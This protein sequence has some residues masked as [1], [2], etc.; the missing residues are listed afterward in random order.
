MSQRDQIAS[1][2]VIRGFSRYFADR[3]ERFSAPRIAERME[4][5]LDIIEK[6][7]QIYV[8]EDTG[9]TKRSFYRRVVTRGESVEAQFG[10]SENGEIYYLQY[11]YNPRQQVVFRKATAIPKWLDVAVEEK[12]LEIMAIIRG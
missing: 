10:Y 8:P 2:Q 5:A 4:Q 3:L 9:A 7:S 12:Q 1:N 6:Q 11:I